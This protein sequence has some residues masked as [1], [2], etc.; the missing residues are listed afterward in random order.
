M[1]TRLR[2][3]HGERLLHF[4]KLEDRR[5]LS[6]SLN[7]VSLATINSASAA[8]FQKASPNSIS[9]NGRYIAYA[10]NS[11]N[12]FG[13]SQDDGEFVNAYRYDLLT[14]ENVL[15]SVSTNGVT[16]TNGSVNNVQISSD[17]NVVSFSSTATN[18]HPLDVDADTDVY[19]RH[20]NTNVT[21]LASVNATGSGSA[22]QY[23]YNLS[24]SADGN[25][26]VF[27]TTATNIDDRD[28]NSFF[29]DIRATWRH[30]QHDW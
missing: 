2:L 14:G 13:R 23:A 20:L 7:T 25:F 30:P 26:I 12:L 16:G 27:V 6:V 29:D 18:L 21:Y 28:N 15:V 1:A 22:N 5:L 19:A 8:G 3:L 24:M 4:E 11:P 10:S 9:A 17:G